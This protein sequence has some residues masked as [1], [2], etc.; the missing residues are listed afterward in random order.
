MMQMDTQADGVERFIWPMLGVAAMVVPGPPKWIMLYKKNERCTIRQVGD[1]CVM[2]SEN[3][4]A[5]FVSE[6]VGETFRW[7]EPQCFEK[8]VNL[9]RSAAHGN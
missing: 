9:T 8:Y 7:H 1:S 5:A 2:D 4:C 6:E 3:A